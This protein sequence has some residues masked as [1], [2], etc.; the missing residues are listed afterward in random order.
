MY[1]YLVPFA[2]ALFCNRYSAKMRFN[3]LVKPLE[4]DMII[5]KVTL[6]P[7]SA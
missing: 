6:S 1:V 7:H 5:K 4:K 3:H 2:C